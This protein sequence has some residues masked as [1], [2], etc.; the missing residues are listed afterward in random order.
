MKWITRT[1]KVSYQKDSGYTDSGL[2]A[3][4][5]DLVGTLICNLVLELLS[6][7][8]RTGAR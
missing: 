5:Q 1:H 2:P 3:S 7:V 6:F 4:I 8:A